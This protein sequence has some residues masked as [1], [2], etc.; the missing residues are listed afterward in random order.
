MKPM[1]DEML[2]KICKIGAGKECCRYLACG[3]GGFECLKNSSL[4]AIMDKRVN[5]GTM[6]AQGDNCDG[7]EDKKE[8]K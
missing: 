2:K 8:A 4:K 3:A 6:N 7:F 5:E 1:S